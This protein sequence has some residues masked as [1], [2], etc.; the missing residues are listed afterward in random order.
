MAASAPPGV[1]Q[2]PRRRRRRQPRHCCG[3]DGC[4]R[5]RQARLRL[6]RPAPGLFCDPR[7]H[8]R[9]VARLWHTAAQPGPPRHR[10]R[11]S[12]A[13]ACGQATAWPGPLDHPPATRWPTALLSPRQEPDA[14]PQG[15]RG[16][17]ACSA[18]DAARPAAGLR[19]RRRGTLQAPLS[20]F[21]PAAHRLQRQDRRVA[22]PW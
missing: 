19:L 7:P 13:P 4:R 2:A 15:H 20:P 1:W 5:W 6:S 16:A 18:T 14:C 12:E 8:P 10:A 21:V 3:S 22:L 9:R 11:A 17:A